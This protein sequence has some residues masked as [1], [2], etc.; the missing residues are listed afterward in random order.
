MVARIKISPTE[1]KVSK[2]GVN[3]N[4]ATDDQLAFDAI[5]NSSY[6]GVILQGTSRTDGAGWSTVATSPPAVPIGQNWYFNPFQTYRKSIAI[7]FPA[8]SVAPDVIFMIRP[9]GDPSWA[10]PHYSS[11]N[12]YGSS[13]PI[14]GLR[15]AN[16]RQY[17]NPD[18]WAGTSVWASTSTN[19]LT[20]RVDYVQFSSGMLNWEFAYLVFQSPQRNINGTWSNLPQLFT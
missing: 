10:T 11:L 16:G 15:D 14:N 2:D 7:G 18:S 9:L 19:T 6:A 1:F 8:Q 13:A 20:L 4:T 3:V 12:N 5:N 17:Y